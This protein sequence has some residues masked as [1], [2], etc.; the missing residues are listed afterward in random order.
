MSNEGFED[1]RFAQGQFKRKEN[2]SKLLPSRL[3]P[4][5]N[6]NAPRVGSKIVLQDEL[7][8][9]VKNKTVTGKLDSRLDSK[10][11]KVEFGEDNGL[12]SSQHSVSSGLK[13]D[14][15]FA[16]KE[17]KKKIRHGLS[18]SS[19]NSEVSNRKYNKSETLTGPKSETDQHPLTAEDELTGSV[20]N[21]LNTLRESGTL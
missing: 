2:P 16:R 21:S 14:S 8:K 9:E 10:A 18:T 12:S 20:D 19:A 15:L 6:A 3:Q 4:M 1:D 7:S 17:D 11:G 5:P 13:S